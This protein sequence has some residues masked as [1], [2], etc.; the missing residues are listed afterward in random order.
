MAADAS[1]SRWRRTGYVALSGMSGWL[2]GQVACLPGNVIIAVRDT[3]GQARLFVET[4]LYGLLAWGLWTLLLAATAWILVALPLV[5]TIRPCLLVRLR[6][7]IAIS[8][9]AGGL[10]LTWLHPEAFYDTSAVSFFHRYAQVIPYGL[11]TLSF[12]LMTAWMYILLAKRRLERAA[13]I[14]ADSQIRS[15]RQSILD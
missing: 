8:G 7:V 5:L 1:F 9:T 10:S 11:F 13:L 6:W 15:N 4:L 2:V 12:T 3:E 14:T